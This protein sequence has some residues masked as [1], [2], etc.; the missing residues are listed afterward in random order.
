MAFCSAPG[1]T[2]EHS[3]AKS[4]GG[5]FRGR[6]EL[7]AMLRIN[8]AM[9]LYSVSKCGRSYN[10]GILAGALEEWRRGDPGAP[11]EKQK[12]R[13]QG[14]TPVVAPS[15]ASTLRDFASE[16]RPSGSG[17]ECTGCLQRDGDGKPDVRIAAIVEVVSIVV[18]DVNVI[19][20]IPVCRPVFR[21]RVDQQE[22]VAAVPEARISH[23]H[24]GAGSHAEEVR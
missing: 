7:C 9:R 12:S 18:V 23:E 17:A 19:G 24:N 5:A 21:I 8:C 4:Q 6:S 16:S 22:R 3:D 11:P 2:K 20:A 10:G 15:P 1:I 14:G 13:P